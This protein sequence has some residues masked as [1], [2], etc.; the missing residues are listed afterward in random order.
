MQDTGRYINIEFSHI[1]ISVN[2]TWNW[3]Q[4]IIYFSSAEI[5]NSGSNWLSTQI[6]FPCLHVYEENQKTLAKYTDKFNEWKP[7]YVHG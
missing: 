4:I 2:D 7:F 6:V 1:S 5:N 3:K